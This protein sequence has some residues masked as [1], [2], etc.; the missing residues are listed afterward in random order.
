MRIALFGPPGA[1]K[2][3][4]AKLLIERKGLRHIST[5]HIIREAMKA[6]TPVGLEAKKY[7]DAG[8]LVP[9]TVVRKLA[10][11]AIAEH[12]YDRFILDGYPRTV[13]QA[14]WLTEF[15]ER[16]QK[17]LDAV[18]SFVLSDEVI[19]DR[20]SKRRVHKETGENYHLD[21]KPPPP[22]VDPSLIIQR[23][24]D[25]PEAIL[26]RLLVYQNE[27]QP[28]EEYFLQQGALIEIDGIGD[29]ETIYERVVAALGTS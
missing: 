29:F 4:Q 12:G 10:E 23:A 3:T 7:Y 26:K 15:L 6:E 16:H 2:G 22:E 17:P 14:E 21:H 19:V 28:V 13:Q 5:G 8:Q 25:Q 27:T 1:G 24:D 18:I 11:E 9:D 20:L